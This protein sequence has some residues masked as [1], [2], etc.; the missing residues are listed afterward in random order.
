MRF[1]AEVD[2]DGREITRYYLEQQDLEKML[3]VGLIP[4]YIYRP[5]K[6]PLAYK[7]LY[8]LVIPHTPILGEATVQP[9]L[10]MPNPQSLTCCFVCRAKAAVYDEQ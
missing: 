5:A 9:C 1:K 3:Q 8:T 10:H 7:G 4:K 6:L 2:F